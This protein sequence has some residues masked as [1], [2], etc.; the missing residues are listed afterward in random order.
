MNVR[1]RY[2]RTK[3]RKNT[4]VTIREGNVIYFGI[5]RFDPRYGLPFVKKFGVKIAQNRA[6]KA[7]DKTPYPERGIIYSKS[8]LSGCCNVE[9]I[10]HLLLYFESVEKLAPQNKLLFD[11]TD[12]IPESTWWD[13]LLPP[14]IIKDVSAKRKGISPSSPEEVKV[15][16]D[17]HI[18]IE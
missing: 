2:N 18:D 16:T 8:G 14:E 15:L 3:E 5:A 4:L 1:V 12:A 17:F 10:K 6:L 7:K 9:N 11:A 13:R